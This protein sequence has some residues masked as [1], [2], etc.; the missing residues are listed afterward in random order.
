MDLHTPIESTGSESLDSII[1]GGSVAN[2]LILL[3]ENGTNEYYSRPI[4]RCGSL[5]FFKFVRYT[6]HFIR[7]FIAEGIDKGQRLFMGSPFSCKMH[8]LLKE[9]PSKNEGVSDELG[10][11]SDVGRKVGDQQQED[12]FRIAWRYQTAPIIDSHIQRPFA[13]NKLVSTTTKNN[14][15]DA[16][17]ET[18]VGLA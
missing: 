6:L 14:D 8:K 11:P 5:L 10:E 13:P 9:I 1:G 15:S 17:R 12:K 18:K 16:N 3:D 7:C 4:Q 2:A